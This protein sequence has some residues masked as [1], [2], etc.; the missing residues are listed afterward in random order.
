MRIF[1]GGAVLLAATPFAGCK[2]LNPPARDFTPTVAR[3][4]LESTDGGASTAVLPISGVRVAIGDKPLVTEG[5]IVNVDLVQVDLGRCLLFHLTPSA[6]RDLYRFSGSNQGRRLVL[7]LNNVPIGARRIEG[8]I[9]DGAVFIFAEVADAELPV[10]AT[11]LKKTS[12]ELQRAI[13]RKR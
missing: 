12:A 2:A 7:M 3:F 1:I 4:Y 11:N 9:T 10:L 8:P 6:A 13:A 5:D